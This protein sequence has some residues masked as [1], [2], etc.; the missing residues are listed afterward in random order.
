MTFR[1]EIETSNA[2]FEGGSHEVERLLKQ[3]ALRLMQGETGVRTVRDINGNSVGTFYYEPE[4]DP[5]A[6]LEPDV[7]VVAPGDIARCPKQSLQAGHYRADG[8]CRCEGGNA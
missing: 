4:E 3:V 6:R 7:K 1:L 8:T 5:P 2:A